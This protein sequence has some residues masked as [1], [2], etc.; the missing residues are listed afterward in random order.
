MLWL[1]CV[2]ATQGNSRPSNNLRSSS[3]SR[4]STSIIRESKDPNCIAALP[5]NKSCMWPPT[6]EV[7]HAP[8]L[9]V[10]HPL[11]L[12]GEFVP[13]ACS[14]VELSTGGATS[15]GCGC[16]CPSLLSSVRS[17]KGQ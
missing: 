13:A 16:P 17:A 1:A 15:E 11:A 12:V 6:G 8:S 10:S 14:T 3:S 2:A 9:G 7:N 5:K 4:N